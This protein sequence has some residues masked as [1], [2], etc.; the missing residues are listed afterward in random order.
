[1]SEL[2]VF[3]YLPQRPARPKAARLAPVGLTSLFLPV[4]KTGCRPYPSQLRRGK[5]GQPKP[6]RSSSAGG[7]QQHGCRRQGCAGNKRRPRAEGLKQSARCSTEL[8]HRRR[9]PRHGFR[10]GFAWQSEAGGG[11]RVPAVVSLGAYRKHWGMGG[12]LLNSF[13]PSWFLLFWTSEDLW[14]G[15]V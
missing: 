8:L 5:A 12:G 11:C 3:T 9:G 7:R 15:G 14:N 2:Q 6:S 1:M 10:E 4:G 13:V